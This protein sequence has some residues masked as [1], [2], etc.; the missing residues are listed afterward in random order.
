[1]VMLTACGSA[2][3]HA[4][5]MASSNHVINVALLEGS[6]TGD[7]PVFGYDPGH[8]GYVN[9]LASSRIFQGKLLWSQHVG[10]IFSS[11]VAGLGMLYIAGADGNLYAL[12]QDSGTVVWRA[13]LNNKLTDATPA[14]E[15]Q[16]LFVST[17]STAL[18]A[19]NANTGAV[20][21]TFD[22][23]EKIQA[24]PLI[25]G[26]YVLLATSTTL[27]TLNATSGRLL[28]KFHRGAIGW[29]T[30]GA[31]TLAGNTVYIGL[32]SG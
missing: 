28:W 24:P 22:T 29:P 9:S 6:G 30:T 26:S 5:S 25:V 3:S 8:T 1:M 20:Y 17:R 27:W 14:L 18:E 32:G 19:L 7:W 16:V 12:K 13:R 31:P 21:W 11:P 4:P 23:R 2:P 15:G 10:P